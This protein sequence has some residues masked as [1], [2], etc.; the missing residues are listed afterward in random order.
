MHA[1]SSHYSIVYCETVTRRLPIIKGACALNH[2]LPAE[3]TRHPSKEPPENSLGVQWFLLAIYYDT[4]VAMTQNIH[5]RDVL[6]VQESNLLL[7]N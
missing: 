2:V 1:A 4:V 3:K 6:D 7:L 5:K